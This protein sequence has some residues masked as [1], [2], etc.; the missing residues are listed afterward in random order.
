MADTI[1]AGKR[2]TAM[3]T[4]NALTGLAALPA[5]AVGGWLWQAQG[6]AA[7]FAFGSLMALIACILLLI[8]WNHSPKKSG[9]KA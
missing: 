4:F 6:P 3:G 5:S 7:T 1:P 2:G 9:N 8:T